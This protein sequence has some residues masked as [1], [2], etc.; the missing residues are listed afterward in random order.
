MSFVRGS[1]PIW[2]FSNLTG[3]PFDDTYY[4]F[5]LTNDFP[6]VPK[7]V[8]Q[9]PNG[10][11]PWSNPIEFQ[12]SSGLPNNIYG[13]P[14]VP[15]R[16]EFRNGPTQSDPL[17]YLVQNYFFSGSGS[18]SETISDSLLT[19]N[20]M[21]T[22]PNFSDINFVSPLTITTSGRH[23]IAP[24]WDLVITGSGGTTTVTQTTSAGNSGVIGNPPYFLTFAS[25]GWTSVQLVQRFSNNG[26]IF[27]AGAVA[28]AF[29]AYSTSAPN[30]FTVSYHPSGSTGTPIFLPTPIPTGSPIGYKNAVTLP[31]STSSDTGISAFVD[32]EFALPATGT[33]SLSNI[34]ITGQ[35]TPLS[36]GFNTT[37]DAP[38]F[39]E[40]TYEEIINQE[41]HVYADSIL[42][43]PK[44][45]ILTGWTFGLN[46][47]QLRNKVQS[48]LTNNAYTADQ[49][50]VVQQ[51]YVATGT[52]NNISV[53]QGTDAQNR[54]FLVQSVTTSNQ[55]ALIQYIDAST[56]RPYWGSILS[57]MVNAQ[58]NTINNTSLRFKMR[59]IWRTSLPPTIGQ[60]EPIATWTSLGEPVFAAGWNSI[61]PLNDP[62]YTLSS[63]AQNFKFNKFQLPT[64]ST[65][66]MYLG[67]VIYTTNQL[68]TTGT[69]DS[70]LFNRISLVHNNYA[71]DSDPETYNETFRKCQFYVE[72]SY[73]N[74]VDIG[75]N[76]NNGMIFH[77][78]PLTVLGQTGGNIN[79]LLYKS[80]FS[81]KYNEI[82][83][84]IPILTFYS[85]TSV[86]NSIRL[87]VWDGANF[88]TPFTGTNPSILNLSNWS[89]VTSNEKEFVMRPNNTTDIMQYLT[90]NTAPFSS[91]G[92]MNYHFIADARLGI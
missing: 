53:G 63:T 75:T 49:T 20:N 21:I 25:V 91:M 69:A 84:G 5:F 23:N 35:S 33:I 34:Q 77:L 71:I 78:S 57:S 59:L 73:L 65:A 60:V 27:G 85:P 76:T 82:K 7:N 46:P 86:I 90:P 41:Y 48:N 70:V 28:I 58:I 11:I 89:S 2:F 52:G 56:I 6:Y 14:D 15:Y 92:E 50:I 22:N 68:S 72:T 42:N 1:N 29:T 18:S 66:N 39:K 83:R 80:T 24:G 62:T 30:V 8:Y 45:N 19:S 17:I 31:T 16:L 43:K 67:I 74:A 38:L 9:D 3:Q 61:A 44:S 87:S 51:N 64:A 54:G 10:T 12:P 4:V 37:E 88:P 40:L 36:S 32:I 47:W 79:A 81:Y 13:D 55:F 26:A